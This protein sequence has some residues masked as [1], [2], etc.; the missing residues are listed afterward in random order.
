MLLVGAAVWAWQQVQER[1]VVA[2]Q[3]LVVPHG[4]SVHR[5]SGM[6]EQQGIVS[7][8]ALFRG[9][10]RWQGDGATIKQGEYRFSG[11]LNMPDV[12]AVLVHG[13]VVQHRVT[14]PEGLRSEDIMALLAKNT[15][16]PLNIWQKA[17]HEVLPD[18]HAEGYILPETYAYTLP[19]N[20]QAL[21]H[22]MV[23]AQARVLQGIS[24]KEAEKIRIMASILEK[25]TALERERPLVAAVIHNRL[26][27][28]MPLQMDP[29]VIYGIW[30]RDGV[31]SGN[32][33]RK[34]LHTDTPWNSYT[35]KGLPPTPICNPGAASLR[36]AMHPADVDYLYF[37]ADGS[38]GHA[39]AT[40]LAQHQANVRA[41]V[42]ME[43]HQ[44]AR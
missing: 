38:G 4:A 41:W 36:A 8:A 34:D 14:I 2:E 37:V 39:F 32:I 33:H 35:R 30:K 21:L 42:K 40:T 26:T 24:P 12:L 13:A 43:R 6:L 18:T 17:W 23:A 5:V 19:L 10:V 25:E 22:Q 9:L 3:R 20:A 31:F 29:T 44:H 15:H 1:H 28:G 27:L 7:S 11:R 16:T